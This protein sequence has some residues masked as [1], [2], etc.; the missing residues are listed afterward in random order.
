MKNATATL[1]ASIVRTVVPL[2]VGAVVSLFVG[3]G[4]ELDAD[5]EANLT[6]VLTLAFSGF[7]YIVVR[8]FETYVSPRFGWLLGLAQTPDSYS[9]TPIE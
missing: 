6:A 8:L 4:I 9:E 1:W 5:V 7:Y 3:W 2:I